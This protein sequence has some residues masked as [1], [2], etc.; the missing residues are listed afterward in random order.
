MKLTNLP[1]AMLAS[2]SQDA[3]NLLSR[4]QNAPSANPTRIQAD[5]IFLGFFRYDAATKHNELVSEPPDVAPK[6]VAAKGTTFPGDLPVAMRILNLSTVAGQCE[7]LPDH[8]GWRVKGEVGFGKQQKDGPSID[9]DKW[10]LNHAGV[11][12]PMFP[13]KEYVQYTGTGEVSTISEKWVVVPRGSTWK[14]NFKNDDG[15]LFRKLN[16]DGMTY[17]VRPRTRIIFNS[18]TLKLWVMLRAKVPE[19][20]GAI[21][22]EGAD[23]LAASTAST[24]DEDWVPRVYMSFTSKFESISDEHDPTLPESEL[25]HMQEDPD[26]HVLVPIAQLN[27]EHGQL[28]PYIWMGD[29]R[30]PSPGKGRGL[31]TVRTLSENESDFF[32]VKGIGADAKSKGNFRV[33]L[34]T[35]YWNGTEE[36]PNYD[37]YSIKLESGNNDNIWRAWLISDLE[38]YVKIMMA[39]QDIPAH[40]DATVWTGQVLSNP[41]NMPEKLA[42]FRAE[43]PAMARLVG[44]YTLGA[45]SLT[46]DY[47]RYFIASGLRI[48]R[49]AVEQ[50]FGRSIN[51]DADR[52]VSSITLKP[53]SLGYVRQN[54]GA[55]VVALGNGQ[56]D[57][58]KRKTPKPT[59]LFHAVDGDILP[60]LAEC[61][62]FVLTSRK[63]SDDERLQYCGLY[64]ATATQDERDAFFINSLLEPPKPWYWIFAVRRNALQAAAQAMGVQP[65][66][67]AAVA[68][69]TG[70]SQEEH[71]KKREAED[72]PA[73]AAAVSPAGATKKAATRKGRDQPK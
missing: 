58:P 11:D 51:Y 55:A 56:V 63:L 43:V 21:K 9:A 19:K 3:A 23:E 20:K 49:A 45:K 53:N 6:V 70:M 62:F 44:Y 35:L 33:I 5:G 73:V 12:V 31:I 59:P 57:D 15:N 28:T 65:A 22:K 8:S 72:T 2:L 54:L 66:A 32:Y 18:N 41:Q 27:P 40:V 67:A 1:A 71:G 39:N 13:I 30:S 17:Q 10:V 61:E 26:A 36:D 24:S 29:Y 37:L 16:A 25:I 14:F 50:E 64:A 7:P 46:P 38:H 68:M 47:L 69:P 52:S 34:R 4:K 42:Q 60:L 48:S